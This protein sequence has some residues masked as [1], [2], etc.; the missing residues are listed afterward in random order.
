[1][2]TDYKNQFML[3]TGDALEKTKEKIPAAIHVDG[4]CRYQTVSEN[5]GIY[6]RLIKQFYKKSGIPLVINTS[7]NDNTEPIVCTP[8][9]ALNCFLNTEI[10]YLVINNFLI[11]P[12]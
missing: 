12:S 1:F 10:D 6:Y 3:F 8:E 7:F 2:D 9:D 4:S 11:H 5:D